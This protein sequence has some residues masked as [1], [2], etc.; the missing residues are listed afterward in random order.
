MNIAV[1]VNAFA[2]LS[3]LLV[4]GV[5]VVTVVRATRGRPLKGATTMITLVVALAIVMNVISAGL[6]FIQPQERGV[7]I[8]IGEGGV[9]TEALH[10]GLRWVIPFAENVITYNTSRQT[11]TMSSTATEGQIS[12]DDSIQARTADG[13]VVFVDASVIF[14][15]DPTQVVNVHRNWQSTYVDG[16]V[17]PQAR[18]VIRDV[19]SNYGVEDVYSRQRAAVSAQITEDLSA[20]LGAEGLLLIDFVLRNISFSPEYAASVER[21]QVAEQEAQQAAFVVQQRKQEAE[22]ARQTAQGQADAAAIQ[23][24]GDARALLIEAQARA[25]ARLVQSQAEA[26]ALILLGKAIED[27]PDVLTLEYIQKLAPNISVMLLPSNNPFLL[28]L[29]GFQEFGPAVDGTSTIISPST[30]ITSTTP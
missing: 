28:P 30:T 15:I 5:V 20:E 25:E 27:H 8:T 24:E 23:A 17:R 26:E 7:V 18:A 21:K 14:A 22:Q 6:V 16:L 2:S 13:Q 29:P 19:V 4:I 9:R 10:P 1:V 3:W 12:G 11:Y